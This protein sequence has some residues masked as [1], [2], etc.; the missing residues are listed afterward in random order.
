MERIHPSISEPAWIERRRPCAPSD[1]HSPFAVWGETATHTG[2]SPRK[3]NWRGQGAGGVDHA[4]LP[5]TSHQPA[6]GRGKLDPRNRPRCGNH[7]GLMTGFRQSPK[8]KPRTWLL[9]RSYQAHAIR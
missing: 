4:E 6:F 2:P 5:G 7:L 1:N 8:V 9:L 3:R